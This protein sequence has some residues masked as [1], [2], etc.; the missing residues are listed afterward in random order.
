MGKRGVLIAVVV[1]VLFGLAALG[2]ILGGGPAVDD[3]SDDLKKPSEAQAENGV[4]TQEEEGTGSL[5]AEKGG[6]KK[7]VVRSSAEDVGEHA[8]ATGG[9]IK[10]VGG[11]VR[12]VVKS[13]G[14][15]RD[16][17]ERVKDVGGKTKDVGQSVKHGAKRTVK[18]IKDLF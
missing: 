14:T 15:V 5:S 13:K 10:D 2:L 17:G 12:D 6:V 11:A 7:G 16:V 9:A 8:K 4:S 3:A 1:V 18:G